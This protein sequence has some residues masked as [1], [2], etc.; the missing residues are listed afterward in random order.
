MAES[1][2]F[3][4]TASVVSFV[5]LL[6]H[7]VT[8]ST[9]TPVIVPADAGVGYSI[10][11]LDCDNSDLQL[12]T[13]DVFGDFYENFVMT[14]SGDLVLRR[15]V[16]P[17]GGQSYQLTVLSHRNCYDNV[18]KKRTFDIRIRSTSEV[19]PQRLYTGYSG[20]TDIPGSLVTHLSNIQLGNEV[21]GHTG[22]EILRVEN[23]HQKQTQSRSVS[24]NNPGSPRLTATFDQDLSNSASSHAL[25][26]RR[27]AS[28]TTSRQTVE[29]YEDTKG[30]AELF[31]VERS[32]VAGDNIRFE[33]R[34]SEPEDVFSIDVDTGKVSLKSNAKLDYDYGGVQQYVITVDV[35][36]GPIWTVLHVVQI[37]ANILDR[38]DEPPRF[39][40]K[41]VPYLAVVASNCS[42]GS[43]RVQDRG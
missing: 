4:K 32:Q 31:S 37:T 42:G 38:N 25:R 36:P 18:P 15:P 39:I 21:R 14:E 9:N 29:V 10:L 43:V 27:Q 6:F 5:I 33:I 13:K 35:K 3:S 26:L 40:T 28:A 8:S 17:L 12:R 34:S 22:I 41:P 23:P 30:G 16:S 2:R 7:V 24:N 19:F 11:K 20:T 1:V